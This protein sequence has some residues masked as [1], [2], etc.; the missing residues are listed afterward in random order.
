MVASDNNLEIVADQYSNGA[1]DVIT[2]LDAQNQA[3]VARL[4]ATNAEL[5]FLLD[6]VELERAIGHFSLF[7]SEDERAD[8]LLRLADYSRRV[9]PPQVIEQGEIR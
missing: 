4:A 8:F 5:D 1:A 9:L 6:V 2:V 7:G 3:L